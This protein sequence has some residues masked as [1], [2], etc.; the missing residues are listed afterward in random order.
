MA[1]HLMSAISQYKFEQD[2]SI[3]IKL[4]MGLNSGS[5][6]AGVVGTKMPRYCLFV[7]TLII[8]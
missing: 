3:K 6:V 7:M 1:L 4:R 2:P 8:F 5:L